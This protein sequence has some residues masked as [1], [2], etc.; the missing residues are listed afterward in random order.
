MHY[1]VRGAERRWRT[2]LPPL[3]GF[4]ICLYIW[5]NLRTPAKVLGFSWLARASSTAPGRP[6]A[7]SAS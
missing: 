7:S 3:L 2:V 5:L 6:A 4:L 1:Y